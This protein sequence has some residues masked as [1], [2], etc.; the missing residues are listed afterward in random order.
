V[1]S[2]T[3]HRF[4]GI[5]RFEPPLLRNEL[6]VD[7]WDAHAPVLASAPLSDTFC[8]LVGQTGQA[9]QS[10]DVQVDSRLEH[11]HLKHVGVE[12]YCGVPVRDTAGHTSGTL[13]HFDLKPCDIA[14]QEL[15]FLASAAALLS[16]R[17]VISRTD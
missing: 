8:G 12:S 9:F 10:S 13:C 3:P 7:A 5:F 11:S 15:E 16:P 14:I 6:L 17:L 4:T 1:N 2:R